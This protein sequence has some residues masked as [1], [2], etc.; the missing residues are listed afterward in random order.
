MTLAAHLSFH[1]NPQLF[2]QLA[3]QLLIQLAAS[4]IQGDMHLK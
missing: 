1:F 4:F 2:M 3:V